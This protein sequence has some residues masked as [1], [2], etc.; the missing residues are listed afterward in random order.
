MSVTIIGPPDSERKNP[1]S[2]RFSASDSKQ[3]G[4]SK[5]RKTLENRAAA[6]ALLGTPQWGS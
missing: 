5:S 4:K 3:N 6:A 2:G 1:F